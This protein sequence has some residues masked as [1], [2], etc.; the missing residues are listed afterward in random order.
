MGFLPDIEDGQIHA[1]KHEV[2][3]LYTP[4]KK[5]PFNNY[6]EE[7][8]LGELNNFGRKEVSEDFSDSPH[9]PK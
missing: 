2:M 9:L 5:V 1:D 7:K 8:L 6:D 4:P 3:K